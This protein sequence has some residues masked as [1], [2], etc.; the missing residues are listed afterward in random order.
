MYEYLCAKKFIYHH[1][2]ERRQNFLQGGTQ[3]YYLKR[4][5]INDGQDSNIAVV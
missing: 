4:P 3:Y 1:V 5:M 2:Q